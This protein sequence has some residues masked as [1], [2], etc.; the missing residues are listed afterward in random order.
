MSWLPMLGVTG[1]QQS[2][3]LSNQDSAKTMPAA[4]DLE[5]NVRLIFTT[6]E[7][8]ERTGAQGL[9]DISKPSTQCPVQGLDMTF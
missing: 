5:S 3:T 9:K 6:T 7:S 8:G 4:L 2:E 1:L